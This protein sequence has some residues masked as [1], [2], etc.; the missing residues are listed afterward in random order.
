MKFSYYDLGQL[1][2]GQIVQVTLNGS[3]ANVRLMD[4]SNYNSFK[5]GRQYR[6]SGGLVTRSPHLIPVPHS[7]RWYVTIDMNGLR[8]TTRASVTV[9]PGALPVARS[10]QP[11]HL[12]AAS[13][14]QLLDQQPDS[15]SDQDDAPAAEKV[16]DVFISH[17]TEDKDDIVRPLANALVEE[18]LRVWYDEFELRIGSSLRRN[19]DAG[20][21]QS[22][23]GVVVLSQAFFK[24]NWPQYELDGMVTKAGGAQTILPLWHRVSKDEVVSYSPSLADKIARST[25]DYTIADIA[26]EIASVVRPAEPDANAS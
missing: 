6:Y 14:A 21:R 18:G 23:F 2:K 24:K 10:L 15:A 12:A 19:I 26:K 5:N 8:G 9:L 17:A 22:R 1:Q 16:Y 20:L 11:A 13:L 7:G 4:S 25:A 3:A